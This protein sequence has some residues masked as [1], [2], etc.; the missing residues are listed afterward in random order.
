MKLHYFQHVP[1][2]DLAKIENWAILNNFQIS[3][4][5]FFNDYNKIDIDSIDWLVIMGGP[6]SIY[7]YGKYP[8]LK[9]EKL[10]IE[11][12]IKKGKFVLGICLGAQLIAD[13]L[14][15]RVYKNNYKEIG[16]LPINFIKKQNHILDN[17][18]LDSIHVF[19]WHGD[20]FNIPEGAIKI[21]SSEAC[22]NQGFIYENKVIGLQ[23][24]IEST[25]KSIKKL[26]ISCGNEIKI[27]RY[28]QNEQE[29]LNNTKLYQKKAN[30][31][32]YKILESIKNQNQ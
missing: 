5:K 1:F 16:W 21:A 9:E 19:Q 2:E 28:I 27:D 26:I 7:E 6:M 24:H 15:V 31:L 22:P 10:M 8:W 4:T 11:K 20:T 32:L 12:F 23:F 14:G 17:I 25:L 29:I 30:N 18:F 3:S 13:V